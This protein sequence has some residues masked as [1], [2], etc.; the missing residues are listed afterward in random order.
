M[1]DLIKKHTDLGFVAVVNPNRFTQVNPVP[2]PRADFLSLVQ[3]PTAFGYVVLQSN[4]LALSIDNQPDALDPERDVYLRAM[5]SDRPEDR[6][7]LRAYHSR[8]EEMN[9]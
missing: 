3:H 5:F 1:I 9:L 2:G 6:T 7:V 8:F 4:T